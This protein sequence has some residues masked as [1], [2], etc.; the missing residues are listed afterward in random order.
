MRILIL[1]AAL[2]WPLLVFGQERG[3]TVIVIYNSNL[4][5]SWDVAAHYA[6]ARHVPEEQVLGFDLPKSETMTRAEYVKQLE[7]PLLARLQSQG[8]LVFD[9]LQAGNGL[10][11]K[12]VGAKIRY[13][14]VCYGVP[15]R[16]LEDPSLVETNAEKLEPALRRNGAAVDAELTLLPSAGKVPLTGPLRNPLYGSTNAAALHPGNGILL[17]GRLDGPS[18]AIARS[19]VDKAM[20]AETDGLWGRA[21]FDARGL[22]NG[23]FKEGDDW[24]RQAADVTRAYG[25]DTILDTKPETFS[26]D[27]PMSQIALYAGWY[28]AHASGPFTLP[29]V[30][31]MPGAFAYHLYSYSAS[32]LRDP[33]PATRPWCEAL[34]AEGAAATMGCVD[35][36]YLQGTPNIGVFFSR[37]LGAG[38]SF[39]EAAFVCQ[40]A[41]SWQ[42]TVIGDPLYRPFGKTPREQHEALLA[43]K[44]DLA[45]WSFVRIANVES[46]LG[47]APQN[48]IQL[49]AREPMTARSAVLSEKLGDL[50][51]KAN[52]RPAALR[53][54]RQALKL[55]P[56]PQQKIRLTLTLESARKKN[57]P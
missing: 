30:E 33:N 27:F 11:G 17:V 1:L 46:E 54:Y 15:L 12:F 26:R 38:F 6:E 55:K 34:L 57:E 28:D 48:S 45:A 25:F 31:F 14:V 42:T 41:L 13:A 19:L 56:T 21:Y 2:L 22:T 47:I 53:A 3:A 39:G 10:P 32:T 52:E 5:E 44:S 23:P 7:L 9:S 29:H 43:R 37:W 36:P 35:E 18:P 24:M 40:Q 51:L 16:V 20:Q 4:P 49:L 50:Y 8:L